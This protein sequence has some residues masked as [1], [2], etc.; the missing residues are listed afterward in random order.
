MTNN[1][2]EEVELYCSIC[3]SDLVKAFDVKEFGIFECPNCQHR[4][5]SLKNPSDHVH[6]TYGD[7]YFFDGGAGYPNYHAEAKLLIERGRN[8]A[9]NLR[10]MGITTGDLLE[11]GCAAGYIL[12]GFKQEGWNVTGIEPNKTMAE[13]ARNYLNLEVINSTVE[14]S[15]MNAQFDVVCLFQVIAHFID[16]AASLKKINSYVRTHGFI[17]VETQNY[18]SITAR[19]LGKNWHE[20]SPPSV[21][22]W[23]C[24]KSLDLL[25][26]QHGYKLVNQGNLNKKIKWGHAKSVLESKF[27]EKPM[28][29][30][31]LKK[32]NFL[33]DDVNLTYPLK[34][35]F[36]ALYQKS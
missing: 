31:L 30:F 5:T 34:D 35:Q 17:L 15:Q 26:S 18:K 9:Y 19:F 20:Y 6:Q 27:Q 2:R 7:E 4:M 28:L 16:P 32:V 22:H 1:I 24:P 33:S 11:I 36:Y 21:L 10:E 8:Y 25:F 29:N 12:H 3:S 13:F 23:F 14:E